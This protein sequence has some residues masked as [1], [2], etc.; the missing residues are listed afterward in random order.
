MVGRQGG[1]GGEDGAAAVRM[2][3]TLGGAAGARRLWW[4]QGR[5]LL[6]GGAARWGPEYEM[7]WTSPMDY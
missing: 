6:D 4:R 5:G 7:V 3:G 1:G 2:I